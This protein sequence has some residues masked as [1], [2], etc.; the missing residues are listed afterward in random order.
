MYAIRSYYVFEELEANALAKNATDVEIIGEAISNTTFKENQDVF[1]R[2]GYK[3]E[4]VTE[5]GEEII[6]LTKKLDNIIGELIKAATDKF[7]IA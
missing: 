4:T 5:N 2:W 1:K 6:K 7:G 3:F